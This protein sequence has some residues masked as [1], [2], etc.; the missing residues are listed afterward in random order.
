MV[1]VVYFDI[2]NFQKSLNDYFLVTL[3]NRSCYTFYKQN[4]DFFHEG[5]RKAGRTYF[6]KKSLNKNQDGKGGGWVSYNKKTFS[7]PKKHSAPLTKALSPL[8]SIETPPK[9]LTE[10]ASKK[11]FVENSFCSLEGHWASIKALSPLKKYWGPIRKHLA[12]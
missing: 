4:S 3:L 8:K 7:I 9:R 2:K 6:P 11:T 1:L 10:G 12:P 5:E